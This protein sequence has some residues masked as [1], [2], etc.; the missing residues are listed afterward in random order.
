MAKRLLI[1]DDETTITKII[2]RIASGLDYE[3]EAV[4][5]ATQAMDVFRSFMPDILMIDMVMPDVDGIDILRQVMAVSRDVKIIMM[6]GFGPGYLRLAKAVALFDEMPDITE[7]TKPFRRADILLAL[8]EAE[9]V[10]VTR[11]VADESLRT[12]E[13]A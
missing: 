12:P 2:G 10:V 9:R 3:I 6:T 1:V 8:G 7:L 13:L 4:N 11:A 5:D